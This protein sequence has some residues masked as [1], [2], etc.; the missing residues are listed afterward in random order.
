M[1]VTEIKT[2]AQ[3]EEILFNSNKE[4]KPNAPKLKF[5]TYWIYG[6]IIIALIAFQFFNSGTLATKKLSKNNS[7]WRC[8][9]LERVGP[10]EN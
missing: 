3:F 6:A 2:K 4:N 5:N 9:E 10:S 8:K 1:P 7:T